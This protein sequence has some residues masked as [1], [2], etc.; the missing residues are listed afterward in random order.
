MASSFGSAVPIDQPASTAGQGMGRFGAP[1]AEK[2]VLVIGGN[3]EG[4]GRAITRAVADAGAMG[5]AVNGSNPARTEAAVEE[6]AG[7]VPTAHAAVGDV[8]KSAE[9]VS[10]IDRSIMALGGLDVLIA[11]AGGMAAHAPWAPFHKTTDASWDALFEIN[12]RYVFRAVRAVIPHFLETGKGGAIVAIGSVAGI[13]SSPMSV[14]YGAA[15]SGL[16]NLTRTV[17][18]EYGRR[19]IRMNALNCGFISTPASSL[20]AAQDRDRIVRTIPLA[21]PGLPEEIANAVVFLASDASS[22]VTGQSIDVDGG[23]MI[24]VP[25]PGEPE[26]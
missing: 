5:V 18:V 19:N 3:G 14:A 1:L 20:T 24:P 17:A 2:R 11:N 9:I 8:T 4:I 16:I 26:M 6:I 22:F 7:K 25:A 13:R 21:R 23:M 10:V 12:L 15:K